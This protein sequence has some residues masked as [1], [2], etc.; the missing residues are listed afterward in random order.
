MSAEVE[1]AFDKVQHRLMLQS[2]RKLGI[3]GSFLNF[4]SVSTELL[5]QQKT[6]LFLL[7][8]GKKRRMLSLTTSIQ[9]CAWSPGQYTVANKQNL[10]AHRC[11]KKEL[12]LSLLRGTA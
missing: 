4:Q 3:I 6:E 7:K 5:N 9:H 10:R 12:K 11:L 8:I 1:K 2:L